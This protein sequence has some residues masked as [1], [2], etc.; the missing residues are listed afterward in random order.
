MMEELRQWLWYPKAEV[1]RKAVEQQQSP[2]QH[3]LHLLLAL[4]ECQFLCVTFVRNPTQCQIRRGEATLCTM[5]VS[6]LAGAII[7]S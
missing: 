1:G 7:G 2:G 6:M 4:L 3:H 5:P